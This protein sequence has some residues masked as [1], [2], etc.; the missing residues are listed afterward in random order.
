MNFKLMKNTTI[1]KTFDTLTEAK[2][3]LNEHIKMYGGYGEIVIGFIKQS[4]DKYV[5]Y[6][7]VLKSPLFIDDSIDYINQWQYE[8]DEYIECIMLPYYD[9]ILT[10]EINY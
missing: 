8:H 3:C 10:I 7:D 6:Y 9:N 1:V 5:I 4:L 2:T